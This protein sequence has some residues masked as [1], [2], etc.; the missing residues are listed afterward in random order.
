MPAQRPTKRTRHASL[1]TECEGANLSV[2]TLA[3]AQGSAP[4]SP[5]LASIVEQPTSGTVLPHQDINKSTDGVEEISKNL[6]ETTMHIKEK[7]SDIKKVERSIVAADALLS[8]KETRRSCLLNKADKRDVYAAEIGRLDNDIKSR[9]GEVQCLRE[10][11]NLLREEKKLLLELKI[12]LLKK[13]ER[14]LED[15]MKCGPETINQPWTGENCMRWLV[16]RGILY[17]FDH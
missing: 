17:V 1:K 7:E 16:G 4:T 10:E 12:L 15:A 13:Q 14:I 2:P 11:E 9:R 8:D 3:P 5:Q 6:K